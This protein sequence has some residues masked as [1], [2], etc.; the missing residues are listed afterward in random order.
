V[1]RAIGHRTG[2]SVMLGNLGLAALLEHRAASVSWSRRSSPGSTPATR[3]EHLVISRH[4]VEDHLKS[5][6]DKVGVRSRREL[7]ATFSASAEGA[8]S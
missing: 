2:E 4:T 7:L 5:I 6:F 3:T 8:Q 1:T